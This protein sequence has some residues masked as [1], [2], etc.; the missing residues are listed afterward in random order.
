MFIWPSTPDSADDYVWVSKKRVE[1]PKRHKKYHYNSDDSYAEHEEEENPSTSG[2]PNM[3]RWLLLLALLAFLYLI[4]RASQKKKQ[5]QQQQY[6]EYL[7]FTN[8]NRNQLQQILPNLQD[9]TKEQMRVLE[10]A[11]SASSSEMSKW[12]KLGGTKRNPIY[13]FPANPDFGITRNWKIFLDP[14]TKQWRIEDPTNIS[15]NHSGQTYAYNVEGPRGTDYAG[16]YHKGDTK[17]SVNGNKYD[18]SRSG[19]RTWSW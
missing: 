10:L 6:S 14:K 18:Y 19:Y 11:N 3:G 8:A 2:F 5:Q 1:R 4:W 17:A 13:I 12:V 15:S 9:Y 16:L 7:D